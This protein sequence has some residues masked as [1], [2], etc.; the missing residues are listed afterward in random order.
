MQ[1]KNTSSKT[2]ENV[3]NVLLSEYYIGSFSVQLFDVNH[4]TYCV[5]E[6]LN[7]TEQP[8]FNNI[9]LLVINYY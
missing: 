2:S 4:S 9:I 3:T 1:W 6:K 5:I 7:K 8:I